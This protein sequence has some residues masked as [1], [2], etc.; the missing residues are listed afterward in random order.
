MELGLHL[1]WVE[2][3]ELLFDES[4]KKNQKMNQVLHRCTTNSVLELSLMTKNLG[5]NY[6]TLARKDTSE[7]IQNISV[8]H[9]M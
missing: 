7:H 1:K 9:Y 4:Y 2:F 5:A 8:G 3:G 6:P